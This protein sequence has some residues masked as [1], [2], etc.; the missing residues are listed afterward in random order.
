MTPERDSPHPPHPFDEWRGQS[1]VF[2]LVEVRG[3]LGRRIHE[4]QERFDPKLAKFAPPH[5]TLIGSSGAGPIAAD[6]PRAVLQGTLR[7]IAADTPPITLEARPPHRFLQSHTIVL[8]FDPHGPLRAL[9]DR[10][11][12]SG[13]TMQRS[14]HAF[15]PHVTLNLY[16]TLTR[17]QIR[18]LMSVRI[19][20]PIV[21]DHL[22]VSLT[23]EPHPPKWLFE[24]TLGGAAPA[25]G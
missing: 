7:S 8:P 16:R 14:R 1:G 23:T 4:L 5:L 15:T 13:L 10:I 3:A 17:E 18:E 25:A 9:H 6:T 19:D 24:L 21:V 11:K 22:M 20:E 12:L 2:V